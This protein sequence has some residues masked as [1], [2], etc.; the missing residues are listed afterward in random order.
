[1]PTD[2]SEPELFVEL[3]YTQRRFDRC[4]ARELRG[5]ICD[6]G[7]THEHT[8]KAPAMGSKEPLNK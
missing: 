7:D 5:D 4:A 3:M 2:E 6:W 8:P 1:M